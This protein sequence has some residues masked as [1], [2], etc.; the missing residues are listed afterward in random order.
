MN[1]MKN[2]KY[3]YIFIGVII[4]F[5]IFVGIVFLQQ[6]PKEQAPSSSAQQAQ[7]TASIKQPVQT[8]Q[9]TNGSSP[10]VTLAPPSSSPKVAAQQFYVYYFSSLEN[11][12]ANGAYKTNPY[13]SPQFKDIIGAA[14]K[15][16]NVPV[17]CPQNKTTNIV[18]D[19]EESIYYNNGYLMQEVISQ[20][21]PGNKDLYSLELQQIN[22]K[23]LIFD[24]NCIP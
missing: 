7:V 9:N 19:K 17:F 18:V 21:P 5:I 16:G 22:G 23:W 2:K 20:A 12:L 13:L 4:L 6:N 1:G 24:I 11:P 15:N 14:Y 10:S 3:L 8:G